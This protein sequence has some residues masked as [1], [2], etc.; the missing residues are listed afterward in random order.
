MVLGLA[1]MEAVGAGGGGG[2][3][4]TFGGGFLQPET[5][6]NISTAMVANKRDGS[7][8]PF[9]SSS[10]RVRP[11]KTLFKTPAGLL[12]VRAGCQ[13]ALLGTVRKHRPNLGAAFTRG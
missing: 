12:I 6:N 11:A 9:T 7:R 1:V 4:C 8:R 5:A 10:V 3:A 2:G 13:L